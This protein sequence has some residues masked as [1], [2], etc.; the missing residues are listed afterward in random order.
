MAQCIKVASKSEIEPGSGKCIE[1]EGKKIAVFNVDGEFRAIDDT[2]THADASLS[3]G[4][5]VD[6]DV[7]CPWHGACFNLETGEATTPPAIEPVST[8]PVRVN[9]D[10]VEVEV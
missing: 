6:G 5:I 4:V 10:D 2:C 8:Y 7:E 3:E 9:G 1:A